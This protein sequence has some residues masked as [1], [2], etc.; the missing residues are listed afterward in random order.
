MARRI[1][2]ALLLSRALR[3]V[4]GLR[5]TGFEERLVTPPAMPGI[6][7]LMGDDFDGSAL[8]GLFTEA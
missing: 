4:A 2:P 7:A 3:D 6:E 1:D 8:E 5:M